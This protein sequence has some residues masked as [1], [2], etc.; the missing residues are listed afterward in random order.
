MPT[1][2]PK[3]NNNNIYLP[4][5]LKAYIKIEAHKIVIYFLFLIL[6]KTLAR[7][8]RRIGTTILT[9]CSQN[10][11]RPEYFAAECGQKEQATH[12]FTERI[13]QRIQHGY[14]ALSTHRIR[15]EY[16]AKHQTQCVAKGSLAP[17]QTGCIDRFGRSVDVTTANPSS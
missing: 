2:L 15:K 6:L 10:A 1:F 17:H 5:R 7:P 12:S 13:L 9:Q 4:I 8:L 14:V 11:G 3:K 16:A